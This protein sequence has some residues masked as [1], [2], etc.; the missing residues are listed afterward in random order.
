MPKKKD[1]ETLEKTVARILGNPRIKII[2][3]ETRVLKELWNWPDN[4]NKMTQK[5]AEDLKYSLNKFGVVDEPVIEEG[6]MIIGGNHRAG[7]ILEIMGPE[8]E[9]PVKVI[10]GLT[11]DEKIELGLALNGI[12]GTNDPNQ[13]KITID[14]LQQPEELLHLGF[15]EEQFKDLDVDLSADWGKDTE[16]ELFQAPRDITPKKPV[17]CPSCGHEFVPEKEKGSV[18]RK[19]FKKDVS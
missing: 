13:L 4:P 9:I 3:G 6:N 2:R 18:G 8:Y 10:I 17:K 15:D 12:H 19:K 5:E 1:V 16:E 11:H 7:A 14:M